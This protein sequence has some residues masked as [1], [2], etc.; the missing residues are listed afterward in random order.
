MTEKPK[1]KITPE[2][3]LGISDIQDGQVHTF[4]NPNG[5]M[6]VGADWSIDSLKKAITETPTCYTIE[7]TGEQARAMSH[8][9]A[10]KDQYGY[11]FVETDMQKLEALEKQINEKIAQQKKYFEVD[12]TFNYP[13]GKKCYVVGVE[14]VEYPTKGWLYEYNYGPDDKE[15]T[16]RMDNNTLEVMKIV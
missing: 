1:S 13:D 12:D 6:L 10:F 3:L 11:V 8:G 9:A 7:F 4:R 5:G 15:P 2:Q 16:G 14:W